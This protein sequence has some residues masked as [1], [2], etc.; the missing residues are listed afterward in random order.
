MGF[1][2]QVSVGSTG[3]HHT[4]EVDSDTDFSVLEGIFEVL[5]A[6]AVEVNS[7]VVTTVCYGIEFGKE[8]LVTSE[9]G[10]SALTEFFRAVL[11]DDSEQEG[12]VIAS[13]MWR[14]LVYFSAEWRD[15]FLGRFG[16]RGDYASDWAEETEVSI[17]SWIT[18]DWDRTARDMEMGGDVSFIYYDGEVYVFDNH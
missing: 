5:G 13:A 4:I 15:S 3:G 12:A 1:E 14:G 10:F 6:L 2:Y 16:S 18:V 11:E 8:E 7:V 17:P 9:V